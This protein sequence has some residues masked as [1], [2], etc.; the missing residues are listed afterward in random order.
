MR[1]SMSAQFKRASSSLLGEEASD[2]CA[3]GRLIILPLA[4]FA[5][6]FFVGHIRL[7]PEPV[8]SAVAAVTTVGAKGKVRE[9]APGPKALGLAAMPQIKKADGTDV[10]RILVVDQL[11]YLGDCDLQRT[12]GAVAHCC[13]TQSRDASCCLQAEEF[14]QLHERR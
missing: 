7:E 11:F 13:A 8:R 9:I 10:N 1:C 12:Q 3:Y 14:E 6:L 2:K 5:K 4:Q